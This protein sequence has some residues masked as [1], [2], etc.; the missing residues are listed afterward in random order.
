MTK[1]IFKKIRKRDGRIVDFDQD[2]ITKAVYKAMKYVKEGNLDKD[3]LRVSNKVV[4]ELASSYSPTHIPTI[5]EVQDIVEKILIIMDFS[6]TAKAYI[7][8]RQERAEVRAKS[9]LI[10]DKIKKLVKKSR[11]YFQSYMGE[12]IYYRTY[13]RW[14]EE[15]ER[16][17]TWIE[18]VD[19]YINFMKE[20][21]GNKLKEDEY[22]EIKNAIL[23]FQVMP[24]MRLV[25]SA[26]KTARVNNISVYN[27]SYIAPN[28]LTDFAEIMYLLMS[29]AG[30]GFSVENQNVQQLPIIKYQTKKILPIH[31]IGDSK[32]GWGDTLT[33]GLKTWYGGKDIKFDYSK[34]RP[35]GARLKT[36]GGRSSGPEP[37][38]SL[39][40]FVRNKILNNQGRRL[41]SLDV[42]DIICKIGELVVMGGVRRSALISLSDLDDEEIRKAKAGHYYITNPQRSMANNSAVYNEKPAA[43][44]FMEEWLSLAKSGT[45]ERGIFNRGGLKKQLPSRRWKNFKKYWQT[46][47][48]NPCGEV[49]LRSKQFCNLTE[50]VA[51]PGDTEQ[52]L[53]KKITIATILGTYQSTLT[54]FPYI[55]K[56]WKK[57]CDEEKLLGVSITGQWDCPAV[58]HPNVFQKLR[59]KAVDVNKEYAKRFGVNQS[60]AVTSLKPSGTVS[61]LVDSA[62]GMHPR[63]APFYIRRVRISAQDPLFHMLKEQKVPYHPEV[64]QTEASATTFVL[65]FPIKSPQGS[66]FRK[67]LDAISQLEY[68]K[69]V[70]ENYTEHNPSITIS[71]G[72]NEWI[73]V[74]NWLY[75]NWDILG[76]LTFLPKEKY[77]YPLA[78]FEEIDEEKYKKL[79]SD[80]PNIDFSQIISYEKEDQTTGAN[81][82]ACEGAACE[83]DPT[84]L[85]S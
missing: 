54:N 74:A 12:F 76:G 8:Y 51:R 37:L 32:E 80:F 5:E 53:L 73:K 62:S 23:N 7:L 60:V 26:G 14:I 21:L 6:E 69:M 77:L 1:S 9:K 20:N 40:N 83:I 16:R 48:T 52:S 79:I 30:V 10:P 49:V 33:L 47:G 66:I 71:V 63:Y 72:E 55:S 84:K 34:V 36:M 70:K 46:A 4:K 15:E 11:K 38:R 58:R 75:E 19:R 61:Q 22:Q 18:T 35:A 65:D 39:L 31:T 56:E 2:K 50:V 68:W 29:G 25:W 44:Q 43:I 64:G 42:H 27:C 59:Q 13:S 82:P 57:N 41:T 3:P 17:E 67:D 85:N 78:P 28:K 81:A 24:S 45:G